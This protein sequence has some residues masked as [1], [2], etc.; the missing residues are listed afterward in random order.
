MSTI[1]AVECCL[2]PRQSRP[3]HPD[4]QSAIIPGVHL[5]VTVT[6]N[7][8][9]LFAAH[10]IRFCCWSSLCFQLCCAH[11]P[12]QEVTL[13]RRCQLCLIIY[14]HGSALQVEVVEG[15]RNS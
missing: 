1:I 11:P 12:D 14:C 2:G 8:Q 10:V 3:V 5:Q 4:D 9:Q 13:L 6:A 15:N 7:S